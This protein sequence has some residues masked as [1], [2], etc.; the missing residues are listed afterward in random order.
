M[1][2]PDRPRRATFWIGLAIGWTL[3]A[4]GVRGV[5]VDA[6]ATQPAQL[7]AWVLGAAVVHDALIAPV[8]L[9]VSWLLSRVLNRSVANAVKVGLATS[10][11]FVVFS[12]ALVRGYGRRRT[13][14][15][16]LPLD[17]G[18]NLLVTI[19]AIWIA[20]GIYLAARWLR[21]AR[22]RA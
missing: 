1:N 22:R 18:R 6:N 7:F 21:L 16:A 11:V 17:Y 20:V 15:S 9:L 5:F 12:W 19:A 2:A 3:I 10:A 8:V 4:Y 14:P 13:L